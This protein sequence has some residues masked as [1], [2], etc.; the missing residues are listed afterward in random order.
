[1]NGNRWRSFA[2]V[3]LV[4]GCLISVGMQR[5][6]TAQ[7]ATPPLGEAFGSN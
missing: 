5:V 3:L 7:T 6:A 1:M 4:S 2:A